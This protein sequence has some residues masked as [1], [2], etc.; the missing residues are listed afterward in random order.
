MCVHDFKEGDRGDLGYG[1]WIDIKCSES[2]TA[3]EFGKFSKMRHY[4]CRYGREVFDSRH[5]DAFVCSWRQGT[6]NVK[7]WYI[8]RECKI[9]LTLGRRA[10]AGLSDTLKRGPVFAS[11]RHGML[12]DYSRGFGLEKTDG[13]HRKKPSKGRCFD[14]Q[15]KLA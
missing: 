7:L 14:K 2:L 13:N 1:R 15:E 8:A 4:V 5:T 9:S 3:R 11:R 12:P 10:A 6:S